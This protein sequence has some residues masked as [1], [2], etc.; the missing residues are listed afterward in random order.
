M[1]ESFASGTTTFQVA[2]KEKK[3]SQSFDK[4]P[5]SNSE[6]KLTNPKPITRTYFETNLSRF[7][8]AG[9]P[10]AAILDHFGTI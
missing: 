3:L 8:L 4:Q 7:C 1:I 2:K 9:L 6:F 5:G 10:L